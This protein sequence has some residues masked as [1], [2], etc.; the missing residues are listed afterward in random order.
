VIGYLT[1]RL[2]SLAGSYGSH[3]SALR[4]LGLTTFLIVTSWNP[5]AFSQTKPPS[6]KAESSQTVI[7][8]QPKTVTDDDKKGESKKKKP[9]R[10]LSR[11][12]HRRLRQ[13]VGI[14]DRL[15]AESRRSFNRGL[16]SLNDYADQVASAVTIQ[17]TVAGMR[18]NKADLKRAYQ[19]QV[20][21]WD[22]ATRRLQEFNQPASKGWAAD[23]K[24]AELLKTDAE[25][26]L[27]RNRNLRDDRMRLLSL[28]EQRNELARQ[29]FELR[30]QDLE[31]GLA[32]LPQL[33]RAA[34]YLELK[35]FGQENSTSENSSVSS[36]INSYRKTLKNV[37]VNQTQ[38]LY[39]RGAGLGRSDRLALAF[40]ELA[41]IEAEFDERSES[42][43]S[44]SA[45]L[46]KAENYARDA[47]ETQLKYYQ[48]GTASLGDLSRVW[49]I[50]HTIHSQRN[51]IDEKP[52]Q[53]ISPHLQ[54]DL[55]R[56]KELADSTR[57]LRGRYVADVTYIRSLNT[58]V[59]LNE[60]QSERQS[61][62]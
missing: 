15:S 53:K 40:S 27:A 10:P 52:Y 59:G 38:T 51:R 56:L 45:N 20:E 12:D 24:Y 23:L 49:T 5:S 14:A 6:G 25:I 37:V 43:P 17:T 36:V 29:H 44:V 30:S 32:T 16:M 58:L 31:V 1:L 61:G 13:S 39:E 2:V 3:L 21:L 22:N 7:Q 46:V 62:S 55:D 33:A 19:L 18:E 34:S 57:D 11:N 9:L 42:V 35:N 41:R 54:S 26:A 28:V 47:F 8:G 4:I 50:R 60:L 48:K